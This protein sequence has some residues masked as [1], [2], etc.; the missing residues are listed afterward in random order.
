MAFSQGIILAPTSLPQ[1]HRAPGA[2]LSA[3]GTALPAPQLQRSP[4]VSSLGSAAVGSRSTQTGAAPQ[5]AQQTP[6]PQQGASA[7]PGLS[8]PPPRHCPPAPLNGMTI[9]IRFLLRHSLQY[10]FCSLQTC[11]QQDK[12]ENEQP[13]HEA[14]ISPRPG[15]RGLFN[16][17]SGSQ[18]PCGDVNLSA[19]RNTQDKKR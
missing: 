7:T 10:S 19:K 9:T 12:S 11:E 18:S 3:A 14:A 15:D 13:S 4:K 16:S 5:A 2:A 17:T 8:L 6:C 1:T